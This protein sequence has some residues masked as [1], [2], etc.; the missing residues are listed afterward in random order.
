MSM[1]IAP[2]PTLAHHS[3]TITL[4][5]THYYIQFKPE[6]PQW[7]LERQYKLFVTANSQR[8]TAMPIVRGQPMDH[9]HPLFEC[10]LSNGVV[11]TI[12]L[13]IICALPKGAERPPGAPDYELEKLTVYAH[14]LPT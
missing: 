10:R 13:E 4:P 7:V 3:V 5:P 8:L 2:S 1:D 6:I 14:L 11:N 9:A 12:H